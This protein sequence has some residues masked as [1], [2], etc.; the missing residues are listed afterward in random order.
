MSKKLLTC[1]GLALLIWSCKTVPVLATKK[2]VENVDLEGLTNAIKAQ[3]PEF[4]N[5]RARIRATYE[6]PKQK[7]QVV[8]QLRM[9]NQKN[10]W[11]SATM[12]VP[13]AKILIQPG[14]VS[15]YEKFQKR[16]FKGDFAFINS[17]FDTA[18]GF[19]DIQN[20]LTGK[21]LLDP[22]KGRWKQIANPDYY[23]LAPSFDTGG[24]QPVLFYDPES[25]LLKEQRILIPGTVK[26]LTVRYKQHQRV[27][28]ESIPTIIELSY[29]DGKAL[30]RVELEF[31][32]VDFPESL[33]VPFEIP[34]GYSPIAF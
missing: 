11:M 22:N 20:L 9:N 2:P 32:R 1:L 15:F 25:F 33:T 17:L 13:I 16:Y 3:H 23:L 10:I 27:E 26:T 24:L 30:S 12:L 29:F 6:D 19:G 8:L 21:A 4:K 14:Q 31:T 5:L 7:Q 28:G 18:L 34:S